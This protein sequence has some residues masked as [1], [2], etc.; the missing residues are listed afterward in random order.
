[1]KDENAV[2]SWRE[3]GREGLGG[4]ADSPGELKGRRKGLERG[5]IESGREG[6]RGWGGGLIPLQIEISKVRVKAGDG[7][8]PHHRQHL[9]FV[10][11]SLYA[12]NYRMV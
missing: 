6:G 11:N 3:G 12:W 9:T 10:V 8:N 7:P 4:G 2:E 1:M 5:L